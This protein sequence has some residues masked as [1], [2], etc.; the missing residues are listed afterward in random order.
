M[1]AAARGVIAAG[2]ADLCALLLFRRITFLLFVLAPFAI[3]ALFLLL[4]LLRVRGLN[5]SENQQ[6]GRDGGGSRKFHGHLL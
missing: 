5:G 4:F 1:P 6:H 2:A 3:V